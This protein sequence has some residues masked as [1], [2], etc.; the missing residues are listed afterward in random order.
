MRLRL[1]TRRSLWLVVI[2]G[3]ILGSVIEGRRL[4]ALSRAYRQTARRLARAAEGYAIHAKSWEQMAREQEARAQLL[5]AH[6]L[7]DAFAEVYL[8]QEEA[9]HLSMLLKQE[10]TSSTA[11]EILD[12]RFAAYAEMCETLAYRQRFFGANLTRVAAQYTVLKDQ[13]ERAAGRPWFRIPLNPPMPEEELG[14]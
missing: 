13:Y 10:H 3:M 2:V 14:L 6:R 12:R 5:R 9:A 11:K 8:D 7:P 1:T 4:I